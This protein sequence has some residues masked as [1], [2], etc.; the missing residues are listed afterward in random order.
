MNLTGRCTLLSVVAAIVLAPSF[1]AAAPFPVN[2]WSFDTAAGGAADGAVVSD[3]IGG[4]H[5]TIRGAGASW[6]GTDVVL[7]GGSSDSAAY[8]DL[9][10]GLI[11]GKTAVT[12]EGWYTVNGGG[13]WAR[14]F[15]FGSTQ[16]GGGNGEITGPGNTNGGGAEGLDYIILSASRGGNYGDQRIEWRDIDPGTPD[17]GNWNFDSSRPTVFGEQIHFAVSVDSDV[18]APDSIVNYWRNGEHILVD[19]VA[20]NKQLSNVNDVNNW[21]GRSTWLGDA[22]LNGSYNEF[23]IYDR[24]LTD[25]DVQESLAR[26]PDIIPEPAS[27]GLAAVAFGLLLP[28][29]RRR[30]RQ[31]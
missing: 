17:T 3:S 7:P 29:A 26:G 2:R 10:N 18:A 28:F 24:A 9:P 25:Q 15:D 16:P 30:R 23:R 21:L 11:S 6:S 27:L 31:R 12:F 1:I 14:V 8:V 13:N 5:G 20:P 4:A 19:A 22:N